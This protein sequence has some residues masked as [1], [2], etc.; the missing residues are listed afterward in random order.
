MFSAQELDNLDFSQRVIRLCKLFHVHGFTGTGYSQLCLGSG[1]AAVHK[2]DKLAHKQVVSDK[3]QIDLML[4][5][6]SSIYVSLIQKVNMP[7]IAVL[8]CIYNNS[9]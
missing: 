8:A 9:V 1:S 6:L 2:V 3:G 4:E 7:S 5:L